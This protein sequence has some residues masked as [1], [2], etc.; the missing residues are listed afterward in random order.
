MISV[1]EA[2]KLITENCS[3]GKVENILLSKSQGYILVTPVYSL[4][5]TPPFHQSAMDGYAFSFENW[6]GK[7]ELEVCGEIQAGNENVIE[8]K[9]NQAV[10]IFTGAAMPVNAETVVMQEHV[11]INGNT[12][13]IENKKLT[14]GANVRL[15]SSQT[16]KGELALDK[17]QLLTAPAI[18]FLASIGI[19]KV[20]VFSKPVIGII[21]TGKELVQPGNEI[22]EGKIYESNSFGLSA[23]LNALGITSIFVEVVDD[24]EEEIVQAI[25]R[26]LSCCDILI[27][28]GGVSV[29]DYDFVPAAL[30]KCGVKNIFHKVKQKP[31]KP[32][33]FGKR[34]DTLVFGLPG[35][36]A[37][38]LTCFYE[39]VVPAI[40]LFSKKQF[41][42]KIKMPLAND[43]KK[44]AGLTY[45]LKGKTNN[46]NVTI[47]NN[48]ESYLMNS[49]ALADCI[50]E[51]EEE[52]EEFVKGEMVNVL[53][54]F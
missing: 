50:I 26:Q 34:N 33:Y 21:V 48:Q 47:L 22:T 11:T 5:D 39:Y 24:V 53:M 10:R 40:Y 17:G 12:I 42:K 38:V 16:K 44:K 51:L 1:A 31:G 36:P 54:I 37:S 20:G 15:Q 32:I 30:E 46:E 52:K 6:D 8:L 18:S 9:P 3:D 43:Y 45:F 7:S 13:H 49:F 2:H 35:N 19:A 41:S 4:V 14:K 28:T 29:G 27:L 25:T 23:G